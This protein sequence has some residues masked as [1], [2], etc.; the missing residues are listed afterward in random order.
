MRR[1]RCLLLPLLLA[2]QGLAPGLG[3]AADNS[4]N[5]TVSA[6]DKGKRVALV[7]GNSAYAAGALANPKNDAT[8][9]AAA[10]KKLDFDV[11]L[12]VNANKSALDKAFRQFS[13]QSDKAD[14]ALLFYA[15]HGVQVNGN[16][17]IVPLDANPQN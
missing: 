4:R 3:L 13:N 17:Y 16:N 14:V 9:I 6:P 11:A 15:G 10:L 8:A 12:V 7:I 2:V 1:F 5:L